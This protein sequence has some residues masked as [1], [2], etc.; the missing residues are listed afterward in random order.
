[1]RDL[2][3]GVSTARGDT[4]H[5]LCKLPREDLHQKTSKLTSNVLK[6]HRERWRTAA[7]LF[8]DEIP[9]LSPEQLHQTNVR[10]Q[11]ATR[12]A[13]RL[14]GG[15]LIVMSG[16]FLQL[17][18]LE[19][20]SLA[21]RPTATSSHDGED[22]ETAQQPGPD[23]GAQTGEASQGFLLWHVLTRVV[24]LAIHIQAPG[25]LGRLQAEMR[26]GSISGEMWRLYMSRIFG[27]R[28][29]PLNPSPFR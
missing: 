28:R 15:L 22:T 24:S 10:V 23:P 2:Q 3:Y 8:I 11:Q 17:P 19:R 26:S 13:Q 7:A 16:D 20:G 12:Q 18:P 29:S 9:M 14:F 21:K 27:A 5:A 6:K 1:M 4:I 25:L